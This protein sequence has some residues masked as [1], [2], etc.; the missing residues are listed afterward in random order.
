MADILEFE[1]EGLAGR[2]DIYART[3]NADVNVFFG[4][5]GSGKTTLLKILHSALS[6]DTDILKGIPFKRA[7]VRIH[8]YAHAGV[9]TRT[10]DPTQFTVE[11]KSRIARFA[12]GGEPKPR[13]QTEPPLPEGYGDGFFCNY[14]PITR[15]YSNLK[16]GTEAS[17][18]LWS[19][20]SVLSD[21]QLE[22]AFA[23]QIERLWTN[24]QS[25]ISQS[26]KKD[27]ETG[28]ARILQSVLAPPQERH[29]PAPLSPHMAFELVRNFLERQ[30]EYFHF[31]LS[32]SEFAVRFDREP[33]LQNIV[34]HIEEIE[35]SI[36]EAMAPRRQL[37]NLLDRMM[38]NK[39]IELTEKEVIFRVGERK[40]KL[41]QL[42]SGEK[43]ILLIFLTALNSYAGPFI[44]DEPELSLH[45]DWQ[46]TLLFTLR[47]LNPQ[48]QILT[49]THSPEIMA[50]LPDENVFRI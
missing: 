14:L 21:E 50:D 28:L 10:F 45:V 22:Q 12:A 43:Q 23:N 29:T 6:G 27:Q 35:R 40:L 16:T 32:E 42:S 7:S 41:P 3:L 33:Q 31:D 4:P 20:A 2:Q 26:I 44:I 13:W 37:Q 18:Y 5:N 19:V 1:I 9:Y 34:G 49:A 39:K 11:T 17:S 24:Y 48:M 25:D 46:K 38:L 8:S 36:S 15:M 30:P 47:L